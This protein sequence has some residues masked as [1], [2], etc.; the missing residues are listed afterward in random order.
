[1][2]VGDGGFGDFDGL[3]GKGEGG[4]QEKGGGL[5]WRMLAR[6]RR[7]GWWLCYTPA[8]IPTDR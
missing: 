3:C 5:H 6:G 4:Q 2:E 7:R 1:L 8:Q